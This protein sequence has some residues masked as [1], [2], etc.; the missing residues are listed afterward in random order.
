[1]NIGNDRVEHSSASQKPLHTVY[2]IHFGAAYVHP[3]VPTWG[4]EKIPRLL[5]DLHLPGAGRFLQAYS[6]F[7][8]A[9]FDVGVALLNAEEKKGISKRGFGGEGL[10]RGP[11]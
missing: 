8:G 1:M 4:G 9:V 10:Q 6:L 11:F 2:I 3:D 7:S 5:A